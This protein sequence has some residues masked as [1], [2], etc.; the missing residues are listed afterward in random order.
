MFEMETLMGTLQVI[1]LGGE[2]FHDPSRSQLASHHKA[3]VFNKL[4]VGGILSFRLRHMGTHQI[5]R[6]GCD[7]FGRLPQPQQVPMAFHHK[8]SVSR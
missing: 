6:V 5:N 4:V 3:S 7:P 8:A 2:T 1:E